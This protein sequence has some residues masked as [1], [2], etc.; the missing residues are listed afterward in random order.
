MFQIKNQ[1]IIRNRYSFIMGLIKLLIL[2]ITE[3]QFQFRHV[4]LSHRRHG[5]VGTY[6]VELGIIRSIF[7]EVTNDSVV[8]YTV[9]MLA[10]VRQFGITQIRCPR[11]FLPLDSQKHIILTGIHVLLP[12]F[13]DVIHVFETK[14]VH[15]K[16]F[17]VRLAVVERI[18]HQ[19]IILHLVIPRS[20]CRIPLYE[21]ILTQLRGRSPSHTE[22]SSFDGITIDRGIHRA[23]LK[24]VLV[25]HLTCR[26]IPRHQNR[27]HFLRH[28]KNR[29]RA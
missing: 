21:P 9:I 8:R 15:G 12:Q 4:I 14:R 13:V 24:L 16:F 5:S 6:T 19:S 17:S 3:F 20:V 27:N 11:V 7:A 29:H 22:T 10:A 26:N 25:R 1:G 28:G 2:T 18:F 23:K